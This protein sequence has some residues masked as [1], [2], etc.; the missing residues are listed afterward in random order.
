MN[1]ANQ[2]IARAQHGCLLAIIP[3]ECEFS[4]LF[5]KNRVNHW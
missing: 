3:K 2:I 5:F 1:G 4:C